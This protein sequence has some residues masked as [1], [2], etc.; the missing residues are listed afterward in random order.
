MYMDNSFKQMVAKSINIDIRKK[1]A[2]FRESGN[3]SV[4]GV[5]LQYICEHR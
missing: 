2:K 1:H 3:L 5:F 4:V